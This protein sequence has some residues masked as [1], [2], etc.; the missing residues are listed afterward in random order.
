MHGD[1]PSS[2]ARL[3]A[4]ATLLAAQDAGRRSLVPV[5]AA[6]VLTGILAEDGH[7]AWFDFLL[8]HPWAVRWAW[9]CERLIL[10][11]IVTHFLARKRW[12]E[13]QVLAALHDGCEQVVVL[14]AGYD[15]LAARLHAAWPETV[16]FELDHPATQHPKAKA[17]GAAGRSLGGNLF[18]LPVDFGVELPREKLAALPRFQASRRT[19]FIAEGLL[20][21]FPVSCVTDFL[22]DLASAPSSTLIFTFMEPASDGRAAFRGNRGLIDSWLRLKRE[23]FAWASSRAGVQAFFPSCGLQVDAI[24]GPDELRRDILVPAGLD[25]AALAEGECLGRASTPAFRS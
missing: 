14:G 15:T 21:Y 23:P 12:I 24:A 20:M 18:F 11:G 7:A 17:L 10:P 1:R 13:R 19:C 22:R 4:R 5:D 6:M 25:R 8:R 16:F 3:I 2:T 9:R